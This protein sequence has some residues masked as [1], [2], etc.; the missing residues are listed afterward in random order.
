MKKLVNIIALTLGCLQANSGIVTPRVDDAYGLQ[1]EK[2]PVWFSPKVLNNMVFLYDGLPFEFP[3]CALGDRV[4]SLYHV[5][6]VSIPVLTER[7]DSSASFIPISCL[8]PEYLGMIHN[9]PT[10]WCGM[11]LADTKRFRDDSFARL[12]MVV[13]E[14]NIERD[15]LRIYT[16]V[17]NDK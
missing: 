13:C 11:S 2:L 4:D 15:T 9:H 5:H 16:M 7:S 3:L 1:A 12:E 6:D 14:A 10:G 17:K 8:S